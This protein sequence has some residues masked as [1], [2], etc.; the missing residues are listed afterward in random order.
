MIQQEWRRVRY[1]AGIGALLLIGW[2]SLLGAVEA[3]E[4]P[5]ITNPPI[6]VAFPVEDGSDGVH[7]RY[8]VAINEQI[9][10]HPKEKLRTLYV[11]PELE[12]KVEEEQKNAEHKAAAYSRK[13]T[14]D[15][16]S[17]TPAERALKKFTRT[18]WPSKTTFLQ[19]LEVLNGADLR[20]IYERV[21]EDKICDEPVSLPAGLL[22]A[23]VD[24]RIT[25]LAVQ[26]G[27]KG[28]RGGF[29]PEDR[30]ITI[31]GQPFVGTLEEFLELYRRANL[32][33]KSGESEELRFTVYRAGNAEPVS[34]SLPL[35]P[36]LQQSLLD[37]SSETEH[38]HSN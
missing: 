19:A 33:R 7:F 22:L 13:P 16:L 35:P 20:L 15:P 12:E 18:V 2:S 11:K 21:E 1:P 25:V 24:G 9:V 34:V 5:L 29:Q 32:G 14:P 23:A 30:I 3:A 8:P 36:S 4:G 37:V 28:E 27:E 26:A 31:R 17:E 38:G 6:I 10:V